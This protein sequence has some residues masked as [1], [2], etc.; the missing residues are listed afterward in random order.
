MCVR[1]LCGLVMA[2]DPPAG[3]G[4]L[5]D[6]GHTPHMSAGSEPGLLPTLGR[7]Y[8]HGDRG[9][10]L[11]LPA[12][13]GTV[14]GCRTV[15]AARSSRPRVAWMTRRVMRTACG[16]WERISPARTIAES[17]AFPSPVSYRQDTCLL[18]T[19]KSY[20]SP[21]TRRDQ[22]RTV[23]AQCSRHQASHHWLVRCDKSTD[24]AVRGAIPAA[25]G[26]CRLR[27]PGMGL[28]A[29]RVARP[30]IQPWTRNHVLERH[31]CP[32][33]SRRGSRIHGSEGASR[34]P[35]DGRPSG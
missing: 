25:P 34:A 6:A 29:S 22:G 24:R 35:H 3:A 7:H 17:R 18:T 32:N 20:A 16:E 23:L 11:I 19:R 14:S 2:T 4:S 12:E 31:A 8:H 5:S 27:L 13:T 30:W 9:R 21:F 26:G 10:C 1:R 33:A 15:K 28:G